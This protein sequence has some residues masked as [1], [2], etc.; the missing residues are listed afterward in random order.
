MAVAALEKCGAE[1]HGDVSA[2]VV[3]LEDLG[4]ESL[5]RESML[6]LL[7][8]KEDILKQIEVALQRIE[9]GV[10]GVCEHCGGRIPQ[11][12]LHAIPYTIHCVKCASQI[13]VA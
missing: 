8:S 9:D 10:Y 6:S 2:T 13:E 12:R 3:P 7:E 11:A 5:E 1:H 4:N